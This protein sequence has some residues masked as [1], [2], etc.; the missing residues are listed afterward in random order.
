MRLANVL[1]VVIVVY[2]NITLATSDKS[3]LLRLETSTA[4]TKGDRSLPNIDTNNGGDNTNTK[5]EERAV[6]ISDVTQWIKTLFKKWS[7]K[8]LN[9]RRHKA[10]KEA[11]HDFSPETIDKMVLNEPFK[12]EMFTRWNKYRMEDIK[13]KLGDAMLNNEAIA[14]ML[15]N[16]VQNHRVYRRVRGW[17]NVE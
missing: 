6:H 4:N 13:L 5:A 11:A 8:W 16:Y 10:A 14:A 2:V 12:R 7:Q 3:R 15:V 9:M 1:L 17:R